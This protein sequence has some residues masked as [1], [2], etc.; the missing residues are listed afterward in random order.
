MSED[1][2]S[3]KTSRFTQTLPIA[4]RSMN[5]KWK[6]AAASGGTVLL[7]GI[8]VLAIVYFLTGNALRKQVDFR[9]SAIATNLSD[10]AAPYVS[11][12]SVL[13][14]DALVA[15]YGRLEGVAYAFIQD[16][17]GEIL[18]S[19]AQ[20]FPE[21]LRNTLGADYQPRSA[22]SRE[23]TVR[24]RPVRETRAPVLEG[25]LGAVHVGI[26]DDTT[27]QDVR[28]TLLPIILLTGICL[29]VAAVL[30]IFIAGTVIKPI[31]E[32]VVAADAMSRGQLDVPIVARTDDEIGELAR[33]I[34]RMRAS[35][36]AAITR[37]SR[38][39]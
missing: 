28:N 25:Q 20:P 24:G 9:S 7:M 8:L 16:A 34:E 36:K 10:A 23:I 32:L 15:K 27:Q 17:R 22:S 38:T 33:S 35:L 21:D 18:A 39:Q 29:V 26:W 12:R 14:L 37:L 4:G 11:R 30:S 13:E 1:S 5:L 2:V 31:I 3:L 6:I 19:S